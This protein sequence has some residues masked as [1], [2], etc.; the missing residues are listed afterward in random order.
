MMDPLLTLTGRR[1]VTC[2]CGAYAPTVYTALL[3]R[4]WLGT[5]WGVVVLRCPS[6]ARRRA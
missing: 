6:C 4:W 1:S 2:K 5:V 3:R